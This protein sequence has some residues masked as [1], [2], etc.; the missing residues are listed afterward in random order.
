MFLRD[1]LILIFI[2]SAIFV[3]SNNFYSVHPLLYKFPSQD[4]AQIAILKASLF[5]LTVTIIYKALTLRKFSS[6]HSIRQLRPN[7]KGLIL[8]NL[9]FSAYLVASILYFKAG[10]YGFVLYENSE[11]ILI[12]DY[13][14][15]PSSVPLKLNKLVVKT[16]I[17]IAYFLYL[18]EC[19]KLERGGKGLL[20]YVFSVASLLSFTYFFEKA[21]VIYFV[22]AFFG[23]FFLAGGRLSKR[24]AVTTVVFTLF[25]TSLMFGRSLMDG[26]W[27]S[28]F[29][30]IFGQSVGY[31]YSE[32]YF[33]S[34][35]KL[36]LSGIS[37]SLA[38]I[39]GDGFQSV[40]DFLHDEIR[41]E[42]AKHSGALSSFAT[43]DFYGLFGNYGILLGSILY[44]LFFGLISVLVY[45]ESLKYLFIPLYTITYSKLS[46]ASSGYWVFWPVSVT[47]FILFTLSIIVLSQIRLKIR[48]S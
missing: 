18:Y 11:I 13:L 19:F 1:F 30:R 46:L 25:L 8:I 21:G 4:H 41:P 2:P 34:A 33:S 14:N 45:S 29:Y 26:G 37:S 15:R 28:I 47:F 20:F 38:A 42:S 9:I 35:P 6:S 48:V 27:L 36:G 16:L 22:T 17:P 31:I 23:I 39:G 3:F 10:V 7:F 43:G 24:V 12:R 40:Y 5:M 32:Y 44:G